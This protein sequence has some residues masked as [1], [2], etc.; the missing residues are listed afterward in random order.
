MS[1]KW[2]RVDEYHEKSGD[3][4]VVKIGSATGW[5]YEACYMREQL[6]VGLETADKAKRICE[7]HAEK[8]AKGEAA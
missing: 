4:S 5:T 1:M 2:R 8:L 6:K 3:Y 7:S